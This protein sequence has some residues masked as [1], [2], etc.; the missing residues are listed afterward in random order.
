MGTMQLNR[1]LE[2]AKT[3]Y[4]QMRGWLEEEIM[5]V[6]YAYSESAFGITF[7]D[8]IRK[9]VYHWE[10]GEDDQE[11]YIESKNRT[12]RYTENNLFIFFTFH[13]KVKNFR[14][15]IYDPTAYTFWDLMHEFG[16]VVVYTYKIRNAE[17]DHLTKMIIA[18]REKYLV[19]APLARKQIELEGKQKV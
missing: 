17:A 13:Q 14:P 16:D 4:F 1:K 6:L 12:N 11:R 8:I 3:E 18:L 19:Y 7:S 10:K 5:R 9:L 15:E 2:Q